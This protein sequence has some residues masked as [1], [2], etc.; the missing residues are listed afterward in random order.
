MA[1]VGVA[2][3]GCMG[4]SVEQTSLAALFAEQ[5]AC[6]G[7]LVIA[8]GSV[9]TYDQPR[10]DWIEDI[11][12]HRVELFPTSWWRTWSASGSV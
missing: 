11:E 4:D 5:D 9:Q 2:M 1:I 8:E 10:H 7:S 12:Q 3:F 6:D